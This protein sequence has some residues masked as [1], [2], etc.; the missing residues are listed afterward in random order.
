MVSFNHLQLSHL[1]RTPWLHS[2]HLLLNVLKPCAST[3]LRC[4]RR[5]TTV[6]GLQDEVV[7]MLWTVGCCWVA[8]RQVEPVQRR[9]TQTPC[10]GLP[11][12]SCTASTALGALPTERGYHY[13][14]TQ[15]NGVTQWSVNN[16]INDPDS[17]LGCQGSR[18]CSVT[19]W[20]AVWLMFVH[21][22][23]SW[24]RALCVSLGVLNMLQ[25]HVCSS[26]CV[27]RDSS[28]C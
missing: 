1:C 27:G 14:K 20:A 25:V 10:P 15:R 17:G 26:A 7:I 13:L 9:S 12:S 22:H 3:G 24:L 5:T 19:A 16:M 6:H 2:V 4:R 28:V 8:V 11:T 21:C 23:S 18:H